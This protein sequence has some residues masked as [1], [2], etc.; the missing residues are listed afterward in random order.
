MERLVFRKY[1]INMVYKYRWLS[2]ALDDMSNEIEYV[3]QEFGLNAARRIESKIYDG[4]Q[5]LCRFPF[6]GVCYEKGTLYNDQEV[7][8][9]HLCQIS[10]IYSFDTEMITLIALWNNYR[11]S[12][13]L[14]EIIESR[15]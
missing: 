2:Q 14:N 6:S 4:V 1:G 15:G 7:R 3:I 10:L 8:V 13:K 5:Q 9:L 12:D 11:N